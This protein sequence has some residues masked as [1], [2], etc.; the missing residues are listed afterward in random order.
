M[1]G[2]RLRNPIQRYD[3]GSREAL[4]NLLGA[5]APGDEPWAELWIGAHA[6]AGSEVEVGGS[7][8]SLRRWIEERPRP[9]LGTRVAAR[10]GAQL[11][12][13]LKV[14]AAERP[15]SL[16]VHPD[17]G[18]AALG[19]SEEEAAR[20]PLDAAERR[21]PDPNPKP[22]LVCALGPFEALCGFRRSAEIR[23][24][25]AALDAERLLAALARTPADAPPGAIFAGLLRLP[26]GEQRALAA[27]LAECAAR[28]E[29]EKDPALAWIVRLHAAHPA[30]VA[31]AAPLLLHHL[32]LEPGEALRLRPGDLHGYL[33]GTTLEV[34]ASSDNVLRAGLT[35]KHVDVEELLR[36]LHVEAAAPARVDPSP[37]EVGE[38]VYPADT[39]WFR[40]SLLRPRAGS[41]MR[42]P[43]E[44][45]AEVLLCL[46]GRGELSTPD[47]ERAL[48]FARGEA[49]FLTGETPRYE[50]RG[51]A[52]L[53]R[54]SAGL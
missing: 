15:L 18:R 32:R 43:L 26:P 47:A 37:G 6:R 10:F 1:A 30:D 33:G 11:P 14:L 52:T 17:A 50:L 7:W 28:A 45:G 54:A 48:P 13:L 53:A 41:P 12:F 20:I 44:H 4:Q 3:W 5:P 39:E 46:E 22:E 9:V 19:W 21:Y 42:L 35:S 51:E 31:C 38:M 2:Y 23:A 25:A 34:M 8:R 29:G 40:L 27:E 24:R 36:V 16:Q 49:L